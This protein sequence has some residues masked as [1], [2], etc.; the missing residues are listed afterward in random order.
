MVEALVV[1]LLI[2]CIDHYYTLR[3]YQFV[4]TACVI[5]FVIVSA[6]GVNIPEMVVTQIFSFL[7][8]LVAQVTPAFFLIVY[9]FDVSLDLSK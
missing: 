6:L 1:S 2:P 8:M 4:V 5:V 9:G 7:L 3:C